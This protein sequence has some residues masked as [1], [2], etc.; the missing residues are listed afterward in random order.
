MARAEGAQTRSRAARQELEADSLDLPPGMVSTIR[1]LVEEGALSKAAKH[2]VS[3][4]LADTDD[5]AVSTKLAALHPSGPVVDLGPQ[6]ALPR[7]IPCAEDE[8]DD[9]DWDKRVKLAITKFPPGSAPGPSGL[10]PSHLKECLRK[11]GTAGNLMM[12]LTSFVRVAIEGGLPLALQPILCASTLVPLRKKD[13]GVRPIAV[14]DTTRR[15]V[16]KVLLA[17]D[18]V[19]GQVATL[20]PRQCGVQALGVN[21]PPP[22]GAAKIAQN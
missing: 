12:G 20:Q 22:S 8:A 11:N 7:S 14:G 15:L 1:G 5:A 9:Q 6:S 3:E 18:E 2:L 4:G 21:F 10:R 19:K 16:G 13:G 17:L